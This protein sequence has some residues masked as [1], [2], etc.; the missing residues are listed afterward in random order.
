MKG[1]EGRQR[2]SGQRVGICK[3][4]LSIATGKQKGLPRESDVVPFA[5]FC[6]FKKRVVPVQ[7]GSSSEAHA[8]FCMSA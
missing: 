4:I 7:F 6:S 2:L 1:R 8:V 5:G 3:K